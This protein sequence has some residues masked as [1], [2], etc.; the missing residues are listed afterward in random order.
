MKKK[1]HGKSS[2]DGKNSNIV[3]NNKFNVLLDLSDND[4]SDKTS[5][6]PCRPTLKRNHPKEKKKI[7]IYRDSHTRGVAVKLKESINDSNIM[8]EPNLQT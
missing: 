2:Q 1:T 4:N 5:S 6:S 3:L 8:G 7:M